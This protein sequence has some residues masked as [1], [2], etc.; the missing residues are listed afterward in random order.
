M[1]RRPWLQPK[2]L[3]VP[4]AWGLFF[5]TGHCVMIGLILRE[6]SCISMS[7]AELDAYTRRPTTS[8]ASRRGS[9]SGSSRWASGSACRRGS[10]SPSR[11]H[12]RR[13]SSTCTAARPQTIGRRGGR[14]RCELALHRHALDA[15]RGERGGDVAGERDRQD[16]VRAAAMAGGA[17]PRAPRVPVLP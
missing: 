16:A 2:P 11:A 7:E 1:E 5:V 8:T 3:W 15:A 17:G 9:S 14:R 13:T 10:A 6:R 4:A 12:R